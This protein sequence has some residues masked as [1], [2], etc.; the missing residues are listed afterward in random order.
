LSD[1]TLYADRVNG[2]P[3]TLANLG[4]DPDVL[5]VS[6]VAGAGNTST[7]AVGGYDGTAG[8]YVFNGTTISA[9]TIVSTGPQE[10]AWAVRFNPAGNLLAIGTDEGYIRFWNVP[11]TS[12]APVGSAID[13]GLNTV[14]QVSFSPQ[15]T[16]IAVALAMETDIF[17]VS[18]RA[19]VSYAA[20]ADYIDSVS[21]SASGAAVISGG[22]SCGRVF[23][24][25]D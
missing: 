14:Y 19:F 2:D 13:V 25:S 5:A 3:V 15:G 20:A 11:L 7:I 23:V 4:V 12:T 16:H 18:A 24:C 17:D 10:A 22:D 6:P 21:F 9:P 8:V 1:G